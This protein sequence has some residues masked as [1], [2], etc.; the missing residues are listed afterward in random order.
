MELDK[1]SSP[2][3]FPASSSKTTGI[4]WENMFG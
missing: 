2:N 4:L 3:G 1:A